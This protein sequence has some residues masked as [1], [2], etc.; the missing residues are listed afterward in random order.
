[1]PELRCF[2]YKNDREQQRRPRLRKRHSKSEF[3]LF[4]TLSRLF[5]LI[6]FAKCCHQ[7]SGKE[8]ES[9]CL[10]F[11]SPIKRAIRQ[12]HVVVV[13]RP[14]RN[15]QKRVMHMQSCFVLSSS[16]AAFNR[17]SQRLF[18]VTYLFSGEANIASIFLLLE[19]DY[20][21]FIGRYYLTN[22]KNA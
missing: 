4:Q 5:H 8:K 21:K 10:V 3:A 13:Q 1:M 6:Q 22:S 12:F 2:L 18:S 17:G 20:V 19:E 14:L 15:E 16:L 11:P 7:S 9:C